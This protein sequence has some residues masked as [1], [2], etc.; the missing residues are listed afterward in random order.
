MNGYYHS[1]CVPGAGKNHVAP[2]LS[3]HGPA[4]SFKRAN[5]SRTAN[6]RKL[7]G[8]RD[9]ISALH[10]PSPTAAAAHTL[11]LRDPLPHLPW[12]GRP[13]RALLE[14]RG[15]QVKVPVHRE[16]FEHRDGAWVNGG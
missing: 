6:L 8:H 7:I 10:T 5:E 15:L 11:S 1:P 12:R 4:A 13:L 2:P 3:E 14:A 16:R 9:T